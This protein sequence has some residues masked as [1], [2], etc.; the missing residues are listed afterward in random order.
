ME[1]K[2]TVDKDYK[3]AFNQGYMISQ[4][5]GLKPEILDGLSAG[6]NRVQAMQNGMKQYQKD[7]FEKSKDKDVI[8]PLDLDQFGA[9]P[10]LHSKEPS[11]GKAQEKGR[12]FEPEI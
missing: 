8:P 5:L 2:T 1:D 12:G 7:L 11:K 9:L 10:N 6:K 4:E 3:E